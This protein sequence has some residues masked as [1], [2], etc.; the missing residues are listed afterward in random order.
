V[1]AATT[2]APFF[3]VLHKPWFQVKEG[4][5]LD[6]HIGMFFLE[7]NE[8]LQLQCNGFQD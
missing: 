1:V 3:H 2:C 5:V 4:H 7:R 8:E 6:Q